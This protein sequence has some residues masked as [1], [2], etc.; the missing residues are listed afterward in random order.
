MKPLNTIL[1]GLLTTACLS[2]DAQEGHGR[3]DMLYYRKV[4]SETDNG[5]SNYINSGVGFS[6]GY[7]R[8]TSDRTMWG[9]MAFTTYKTI[10]SG[11]DEFDSQQTET[12]NGAIVSYS[13]SQ[14][15]FGLIFHSDYAFTDIDRV[16]VFFG[17]SAGIM[18]VGYK[19]V[20]TD[21]SFYDRDESKEGKIIFPIGARL[22]FRTP[23]MWS[24]YAGVGL[25][26]GNRVFDGYDG[27]KNNGAEISSTYTEFG[28]AWIW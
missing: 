3:Y 25:N 13:N 1:L 4:I 17:P 7:D 28:I 2:V 27:L 15:V 24:F 19:E 21:N 23:G 26:L 5:E 20:I 6:I 14:S 12:D 10:F 8:E 9:V 22:G 16:H 11:L 18:R